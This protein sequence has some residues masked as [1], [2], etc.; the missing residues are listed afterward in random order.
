M[1]ASYAMIVPSFGIPGYRL[2]RI[3]QQI[4]VLMNLTLPASKA[5]HKH[6]AHLQD[7]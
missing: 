1:L 7:G 6:K 5:P 4:E 2:R 3:D